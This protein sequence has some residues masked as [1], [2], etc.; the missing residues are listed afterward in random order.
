MEDTQSLFKMCLEEVDRMLSTKHVVGEPITV[1]G[2][3][4]FPLVSI[5][6]AFGAGGGSGEAKKGEGTGGGAGTGAGGGVKPVGVIIVNK[7]GV[8]IETLHG[9][10]VSV[11]EKVADVAASVIEKRGGKKED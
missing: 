1:E 9:S 8:K 10:F 11:A 2:N 4:I 5:G 7:D 6:F 3:T